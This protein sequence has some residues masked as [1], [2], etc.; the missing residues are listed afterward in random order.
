MK[1]LIS[2]MFGF[3]VC[4][5]YTVNFLFASDAFEEAN[6][7]KTESVSYN[8]K[9]PEK[10]RGWVEDFWTDWELRT[11]YV[12]SNGL[13]AIHFQIFKKESEAKSTFAP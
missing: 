5:L 7:L 2:T 1:N 13:G 11:I 4:F 3:L 6:W 10:T 8:L 12:F 9:L